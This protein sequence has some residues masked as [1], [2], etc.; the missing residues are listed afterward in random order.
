MSQGPCFLRATGHHEKS[1]KN[2]WEEGLSRENSI[3]NWGERLHI[4][5]HLCNMPT[6]TLHMCSGRIFEDILED[7]L[8]L[9]PAKG[10]SSLV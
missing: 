1:S 4:R 2:C 6:H 7:S 10:Q 9:C 5:Y 3:G 8:S